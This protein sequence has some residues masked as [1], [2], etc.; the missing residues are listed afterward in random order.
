[1]KKHHLLLYLGYMTYRGNFFS[2]K[3]NYRPFFKNPKLIKITSITAF[4]YEKNAK[5]LT[6]HEFLYTLIVIFLIWHSPEAVQ[7]NDL[8]LFE[9]IILYEFSGYAINK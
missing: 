7:Y 5:Y 6:K 1:V 4:I 8:R 2:K 3:G 9:C